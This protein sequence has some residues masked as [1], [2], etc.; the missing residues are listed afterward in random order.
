MQSMFFEKTKAQT[1]EERF[2]VIMPHYSGYLMIMLFSL[3]LFQLPMQAQEP[4]KLSLQ[5]AIDYALQ[6]NY[7]LLNAKT[8]E[9]IAGKRV[10]EITADGLPQVNASVG[11]QYFLDIPTNLIPANV[12]PVPG[13]DPDGFL[14][15]KFGTEHNLNAAVTVSQLIFDGSY[16]VGLQAARIFRELTGRNYKRS[17]SEIKSLVTESYYLSLATTEN[18][19]VIR[20]N[21]DNLQKNLFETE[22]LF[23]QGFVD[24]MNLD[25]LRLTVANLKNT[26]SGFERQ[27]KFTRDLLKYQ[28]GLDVNQSLEL[29]EDLIQLLNN[30]SIDNFEKQTFDPQSHIDYQVFLSQEKMQLMALKRQKSFYMPTVSAFY[31]HQQNAMRREFTFFD[32]S[33]PWFPTSIIG[34]NINIPIFSSGLRNS[35]VQQARLELNKAKNN[36]MMI[37]QSLLL[38]KMEAENQ[39]QTAL[40]KYNSEKENVKLAERIL[41]HTTIRHREGLASSLELTQA[42][43]QLLTTQGNYINAI[44]ELLNANNKLNKA[45]G[46]L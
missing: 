31:T 16:I 20:S 45:L 7:D 27:E 3:F 38:Q 41:N 37:E 6:H 26:I 15:V 35:R 44:F 28:I 22:K 5:Q 21:L 1:Q 40:E 8:D 14:E 24:A 34:L 10:W 12:F 11:Y 33:Q 18:L 9:I 19:E 23:E 4:V 2:K 13:V 32:N 43:D 30:I 25:Q 42:S 29:T 36:T 39:I 46:R 17:E